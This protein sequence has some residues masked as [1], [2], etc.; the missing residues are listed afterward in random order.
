MQAAGSLVLIAAF[1]GIAA[2]AIAL[3]VIIAAPILA[4]PFFILGFGAFLVWRGK[5]RADVTLSKRAGGHV[6]STAEA[7]ADPVGDSGVA[8][9]AG[10]GAANRRRAGAPDA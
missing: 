1:L 8:T 2:L 3:G 9:A 7:A 4:V 5:R 6:P 10:S